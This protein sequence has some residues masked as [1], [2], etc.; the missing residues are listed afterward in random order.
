MLQIFNFEQGTPEWHQARCGVIT[1]SN[2]SDVLA[3]G[4]GKTRAKYMRKLV[5]QRI[6][7]NLSGGF[8][9]IHTDRGT[10]YEE[11]ARQAYQAYTGNEIAKCGFMKDEYGYSPDGLVG[12]DGLIELKTRLD[13]LQ[14][15]LLLDGRVPSEHIAQIQGGLMVSGRQWCDFSAYSPGLPVFIS[16]VERD[17]EYIENLRKELE[18][19]EQE[20]QD[21]MEKI[22]SMF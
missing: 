2:F 3:K 22:M 15:E 12:E 16:R 18:K 19:F 6:T 10:E 1:A 20:I 21:T 14:I 11:Q 17:E 5:A 9:N 8:S 7:E 4:Q 13:D